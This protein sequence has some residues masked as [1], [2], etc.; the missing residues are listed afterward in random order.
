MIWHERLTTFVR[1]IIEEKKK[2]IVAEPE[3]LKEGLL[4]DSQAKF[5]IYR[6]K[7]DLSSSKWNV[8]FHLNL[9]HKNIWN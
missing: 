1:Y 6:Q 8:Q 9:V 4:D 7:H 3:F 2:Q 5:E